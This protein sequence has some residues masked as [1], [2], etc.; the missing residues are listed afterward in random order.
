MT[1]QAIADLLHRSALSICYPWA[2]RFSHLIGRRSQVAVVA[3]WHANRLLVVEH[4][5]WRGQTLPGGH[6]GSDEQ[7]VVAAARELQEEVG[8]AIAPAEFRLVGRMELRRTHLVLFECRLAQAPR[9]RID[10]RE[11]TAA[12]FTAPAA[13]SSPSLALRSYLRARYPTARGGRSSTERQ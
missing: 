7:P 1:R 11:I 3:A 10:N 2:A 9:I 6:V 12:A 5:Y 8:I 4:S 13:I